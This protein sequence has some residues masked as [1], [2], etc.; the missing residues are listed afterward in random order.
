MMAPLKK[1]VL[2][3]LSLINTH[4]TESVRW[5][6]YSTVRV[7]AHKAKT[8]RDKMA[9]LSLRSCSCGRHDLPVSERNQSAQMGKLPVSI[10]QKEKEE[11]EWYM[12]II[13]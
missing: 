10:A 5:L 1:A 12:L 3:I 9:C 8:K 7:S 4:R 11:E 13:Y 6:Q 2:V